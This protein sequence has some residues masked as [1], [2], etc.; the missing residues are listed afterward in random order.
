MF[1]N[2]YFNALF[3]SNK[4]LVLSFDMIPEINF[5]RNINKSV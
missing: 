5:I 3:E 2:K 1:K 4:I